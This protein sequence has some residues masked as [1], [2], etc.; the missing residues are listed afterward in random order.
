MNII[1]RV[2]RGETLVDV[3]RSCNMN[4][5]AIG[6]ILKNKDKTMEH[7]TSAVPVMSTIISQKQGKVDGGDGK[8]S[9]CVDAGSASVL[10]PVQLSDDSRELK[11]FMK[12]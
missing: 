7:A 8:T 5:S 1:E 9:Q 3:A 4:P 2:P 6:R 11:A 12:A 10:S